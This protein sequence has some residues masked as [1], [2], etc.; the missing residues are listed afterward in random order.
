MR[1]GSVSGFAFLR[2]AAR[3]PS[4]LLAPRGAPAR[5]HFTAAT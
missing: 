1:I 2:V 5:I 3:G 4:S